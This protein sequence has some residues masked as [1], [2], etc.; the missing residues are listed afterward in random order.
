MG[1]DEFDVAQRVPVVKSRDYVMNI[2]LEEFIINVFV[3]CRQI[4]VIKN[5]GF[6]KTKR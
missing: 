1:C 4:K 5:I 6:C 2:A 3:E